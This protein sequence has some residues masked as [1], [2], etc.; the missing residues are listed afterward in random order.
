MQAQDP[1]MLVDEM[2]AVEY[3][4][5]T[6]NNFNDAGKPTWRIRRIW[7]IG[8]VWRFGYP[9]GNQGFKYVWDDRY[10]YTYK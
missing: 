8:S 6:S 9:D 5:G 4:V 7:K 10:G 2:S 3:F 1:I